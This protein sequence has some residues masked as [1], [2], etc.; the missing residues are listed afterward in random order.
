[1]EFIS[2]AFKNEATPP[3][4]PPSNGWASWL[5]SS[6]TN[7]NNTSAEDEEMFSLSFTKVDTKIFDF[8]YLSV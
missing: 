5:P 4:P 7:N 3:P 8:N 2:N 1:M 6:V